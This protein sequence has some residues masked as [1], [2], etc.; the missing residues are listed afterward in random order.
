[1]GSVHQFARRRRFGVRRVWLD[2]GF[3]VIPEQGIAGLATGE[4]STRVFEETRFLAVVE[5]RK[6]RTDYFKIE[7]HLIIGLLDV[8]S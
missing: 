4:R 6:V 1:M 3:G 2:L 8:Q 7:H 5:R